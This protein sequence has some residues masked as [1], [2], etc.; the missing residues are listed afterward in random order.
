MSAV[1]LSIYQ[2]AGCLM[3]IFFEGLFW[4]YDWTDVEN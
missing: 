2:A 3:F 1:K 4:M